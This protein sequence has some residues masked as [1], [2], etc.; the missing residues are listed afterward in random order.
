MRCSRGCSKRFMSGI[1]RNWSSLNDGFHMR[2]W[3]GWIKRP[4]S[5]SQKVFTYSWIQAGQMTENLLLPTKIS[6]LVQKS[7]SENLSKKSIIPTT[8]SSTNS[9]PP[10]VHSTRDSTPTTIKSQIPS[11]S[12]SAAK[13]SFPA[14]NVSTNPTSSK[15]EC[16]ISA[17][18]QPEWKIT[19]KPSNMAFL[20]TQV[21]ESV[22]K[23]SLCFFST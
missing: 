1:E 9:L 15:N 16:K 13:K 7:N 14:A 17:S 21:V 18:Q 20:P 3:F 4:L 5:L 19:W 8:T 12:S 23:D 22:S 10:H 2:T 11:T 6:A